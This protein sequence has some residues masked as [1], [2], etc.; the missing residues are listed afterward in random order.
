MSRMIIEVCDGI[1]T[2]VYTDSLECFQVEITD[3]DDIYDPERKDDRKRLEHLIRKGGMRDILNGGTPQ[4]EEIVALTMDP[5]A[6]VLIKD[7]SAAKTDAGRKLQALDVA[8]LDGYLA[9]SAKLSQFITKLYREKNPEA[10]LISHCL[11]PLISQYSSVYDQMCKQL[12]EKAYDKL[13]KAP[14]SK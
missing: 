14:E 3:P 12:N 10:S 2:E 7:D 8:Y 11:K 4:N 1:V 9:A 13:G 5:L 6:F